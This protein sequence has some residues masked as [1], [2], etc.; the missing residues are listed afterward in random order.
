VNIEFKYSESH[1]FVVKQIVV[2]LVEREGL[3]GLHLERHRHLLLLRL[4]R[5]D[6]SHEAHLH[7]LQLREQVLQLLLVA[8]AVV[9]HLQQ[10][11]SVDA[12]VRQ[13]LPDLCLD[14]QQHSCQVVDCQQ[15]VFVVG[16]VLVR[17]IA[18][19][20]EEQVFIFL[21][22][23]PVVRYQNLRNFKFTFH[24]LQLFFHAVQSCLVRVF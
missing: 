10:L 17:L 2:E 9:A 20:L 11:C 8:L 18:A 21:N 16:D 19:H 4:Q 5:V 7:Q 24:C 23:L 3:L 6:V 15:P 12:V 13:Q 22:Q 14:G 1:V